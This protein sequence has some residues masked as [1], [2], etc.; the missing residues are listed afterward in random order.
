MKREIGF[1]E[2]NGHETPSNSY[3]GFYKI[4]IAGNIQIIGVIK[5]ET[6]E[7]I[8]LLPHIVIREYNE[9]GNPIYELNSE[10]PAEISRQ[11]FT[12]KQP[13]GEKHV[14]SYVRWF[15]NHESGSGI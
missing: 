1:V 4:G 9:K 11:H 12:F 6:P 14:K 10:D 3:S 15:E 13:I 8:V 7:K 5:E 2:T